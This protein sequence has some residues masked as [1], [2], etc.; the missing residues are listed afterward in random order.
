MKNKTLVEELQRMRFLMETTLISEQWVG[1]GKAL[2]GILEKIPELG[3]KFANEISLLAKAST[4]EDAIEILAKLANKEIQF[5]RKIIPEVYKNLPDEIFREVDDIILA[6]K[7][8]VDGGVPVDSQVVQKA[9]DRR[10]AALKVPF[11]EIK[12]ILKADINKALGEYKPNVKPNPDPNTPRPEDQ[13][14]LQGLIDDWET[15]TKG[16]ITPKDRI[17]LMKNI[18][19]RQARAIINLYCNKF[20]NSFDMLEK[21]SVEK[22]A[23]LLKQAA[24]DLNK[25][26]KKTGMLAPE[27]N[28]LLYRTIQAE[29]EALRKSQF[30]YMDGLYKQLQEI[31]TKALG[32]YSNATKIV[33]NLK[34]QE[35]LSKDSQSYWRY[36]MD[37]TYFKKLRALPGKDVEWYTY[38]WNTFLR[39]VSF[40]GTGQLRKFGEIEME[41]LRNKSF[42]GGLGYMWLYFTALTK[43]WMPFLY[44]FFDAA[45]YGFIRDTPAEEVEGEYGRQFWNAFR[46]NMA[47]AFLS[48][49]EQFDAQLGENV[50]T[51]EIDVP[52]SVVKALI[53]FNFYGDDILGMLNAV[54][55]GRL[56]VYF[57]ERLQRTRRIFEDAGYEIPTIPQIPNV[58]RPQ[59]P[60]T[61]IQ[62]KGPSRGNTGAPPA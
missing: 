58:E 36:L 24:E 59:L 20:W 16:S 37:D 11:D 62:T 33:D 15:I 44:S 19:F 1:V 25:V 54:S 35:S 29:I 8:Q 38:L 13:K 52:K 60:D 22:M 34:A 30:L 45:Y 2:A 7:K 31:L 14:T 42:L 46:T 27:V 43:I 57:E 32:S 51:N 6:A 9:I 5:A 48:F 28:T 26:D 4:E 55:S 23:G 56:K 50:E 3:P 18:P 47:D 10:V 12:T 61:T 21:K 49:Q 41:F 53:P 17:L 39:S 40:V